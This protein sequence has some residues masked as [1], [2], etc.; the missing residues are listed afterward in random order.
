ML[1]YVPSLV[2]KYHFEKKN[3]KVLKNFQILQQELPIQEELTTVVMFADIAGFTN[4]SEK[5]AEKGSEVLKLVKSK[6]RAQSC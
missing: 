3:E 2:L 4:L 1:G 5:L 6:N